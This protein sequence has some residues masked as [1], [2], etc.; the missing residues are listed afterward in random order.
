MASIELRDA[1]GKKVGSRDLPADVF[2]YDIRAG[3]G[4]RR[5]DPP[6]PAADDDHP[7]TALAHADSISG[8][9]VP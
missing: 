2:Q 8:R 5:P 4:T 3:Q 1:Q 7:V 6:E 9:G